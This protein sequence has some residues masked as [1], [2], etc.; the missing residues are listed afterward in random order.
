[1]AKFLLVYANTTSI[2]N[3]PL[4]VSVLAGV[5]RRASHEFR[6]FDTSIYDCGFS[7][8]MN[9]VG[10]ESLEFKQVSNIERLPKQ[11]EKEFEEVLC[12]LYDEIDSMKPD[13]IGFS[14]LSDHYSFAKK[15]ATKVKKEYSI[16]IIFG[17]THAT[18]APEILTEVPAI[19]I[20]CIGEGEQ[21]LVELLD[22]V[23]QGGIKTTIKNLY[24]KLGDQII[25]NEQRPLIQNLDDLPFLDWQD[26]QDIA[27]YK[28]FLG[29]VYRNG[30]FVIGR[31]CPHPCSYCINSYLRKMA[32][33][34]KYAGRLK[35]IDYLMEELNTLIIRYK[36]E[37]VK[38]WDETFLLMNKKYFDT[39]VDRYKRE[40]GLPFTIETTAESIKEYTAKKLVEANC[41]SASIG[42]ETGSERL[43][44]NVLG[45]N[46]KNTIYQKCFEIM[47][48]YGIRKVANYMFFI[49]TETEKDTWMNVE[50]ARVWGID[51]PNAGILYPYKGTEIRKTILK[52]GY[53]T[54]EKLR[55]LEEDYNPFLTRSDTVLEFDNSFKE[56]AMHIFKNFSLYQILPKSR[57]HAIERTSLQDEK[58][59]SLLRDLKS[60]AYFKRYGEY[61]RIV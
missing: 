58:A 25:K 7:E 57:W 20:I 33:G 60:E 4:S 52:T 5:V 30:D 27:F 8:N 43:R 42:L 22:S 61:P 39:F 45:K 54:E 50:S 15:I 46:T 16:P 28:P 35:S 23:D 29:N 47:T 56:K 55:R 36:I 40:I 10:E 53:V 14:C 24:F 31:G 26:F 19:D 11:I 44:K 49:P 17:G 41:V 34:Q 2:G 38:F 1:M 9:K 3:R 18:V 59:R 51:S 37:F 48:K 6:L 12:D 13:I 21:A 32:K